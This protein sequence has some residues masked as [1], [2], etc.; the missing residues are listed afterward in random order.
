M[1]ISTGLRA[2]MLNT[3]SVSAALT[4][5]SIVIYSGTVPANADAALAGNTVLV[6]I[7]NGGSGITFE[8]SLSSGLLVKNS[9]ETWSGTNSNSG[10]AT[11]YRWIMPGDDGT[12]ST[13]QIRAQ[14]TVGVLLAGLLVQNTALVSGQTQTISAYSLGEPIGS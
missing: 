5:G 12:L 13:T 1:F 9:S 11:F 4:G 2:Y 8:S 3:G 6:T 14:G 7:T 10:T